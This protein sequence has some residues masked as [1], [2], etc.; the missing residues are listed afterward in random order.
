[1][2][3]IRRLIFLAYPGS[4]N[5]ATEK[6]AKDSFLGALT[7]RWL[8]RKKTLDET[9]TAALKIESYQQMEP[10]ECRRKAGNRNTHGVRGEDT[11]AETLGDTVRSSVPDGRTRAMAKGYRKS[12]G[13]VQSIAGRA[14]KI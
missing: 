11:D 7:D 13:S 2:Q 12:V 10:E 3:D 14:S 4:P 6:I 9:F 1:M 5:K 8:A